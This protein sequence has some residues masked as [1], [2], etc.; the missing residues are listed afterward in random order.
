MRNSAMANAMIAPRLSYMTD[1]PRT[2]PVCASWAL[3]Q[4]MGM[5]RAPVLYRLVFRSTLRK[6][7]CTPYDGENDRHT[8]VFC[9]AALL[10]HRAHEADWPSTPNNLALF[11]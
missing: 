3:A 10:F 7:G 6:R 4:S 2:G 8:F 9:G 1:V 11:A 5:T